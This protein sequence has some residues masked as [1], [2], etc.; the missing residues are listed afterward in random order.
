MPLTVFSASDAARALLPRQGHIDFRMKTQCVWLNR[1]LAGSPAVPPEAAESSVPPAPS[2]ASG[3]QSEGVEPSR[4]LVIEPRPV[5]PDRADEVQRIV[6]AVL[7]QNVETE[8][9]QL[10]P[11]K[12]DDVLR[13]VFNGNAL[14]FTV[15]ETS[16]A[17]VN[18][19]G[20]LSLKD[21]QIKTK[22]LWALP[23][24]VVLPDN[25][26]IPRSR[27]V[28]EFRRVGGGVV[29]HW[30]YLG[31]LP[32]GDDDRWIV[33]D[34]QD[35]RIVAVSLQVPARRLIPTEDNY[36]QRGYPAKANESAWMT[37]SPNCFCF[38]DPARFH[39][40]AADG[41]ESPGRFVAAGRAI[42]VIGTAIRG[43]RAVIGEYVS[44]ERHTA[45]WSYIEMW[46]PEVVERDVRGD[47]P[48]SFWVIVAWSLPEKDCRPPFRVRLDADDSLP[49]PQKEVSSTDLRASMGP[50]EV[51]DA[52]LL[53]AQVARHPSGQ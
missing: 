48:Q 39:L 41:R 35:Q 9:A 16:Y 52:V 36:R 46:N 34:A 26:Y 4:A 1:P 7:E 3:Q 44:A 29:A 10:H 2:A 23:S 19:E 40:L 32:F 24:G 33:P 6:W 18:K 49:V 31:N 17:I 27:G 38:F 11:L 15:S 20:Q 51:E 5:S 47:A 14:E 8:R 45:F 22:G 42:N 43:D 37:L 21:L 13:G 30:Y 25:T 28:W 12:R 50:I 53:M